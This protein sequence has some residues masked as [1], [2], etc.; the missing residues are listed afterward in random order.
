MDNANEL[1]AM[2][3]IGINNFKEKYNC[4]ITVLKCDFNEN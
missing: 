3:E 4:K 1:K 2:E